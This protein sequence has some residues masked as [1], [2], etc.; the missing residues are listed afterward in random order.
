LG[1][2]CPKVLATTHFHELFNADMLDPD[3]HRIQFAHMQVMLT[4]SK[5]QILA[6]GGGGS[7]REETTEDDDD[8]DEDTGR[9]V[10]SAR[11]RITYL[12]R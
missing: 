9:R 10:L 12:Y 11:E 8:D 1:S 6:G 4:S 5:G 2:D 7:H 3:D